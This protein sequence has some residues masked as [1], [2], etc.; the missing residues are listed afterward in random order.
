MARPISLDDEAVGPVSTEDLRSGAMALRS[1][2]TLPPDLAVQPNEQPSANFRT[3]PKL[4]ISLS[5]FKRCLGAQ[6]LVEGCMPP[7]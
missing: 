7:Q 3:P 1:M 6:T 4:P 5:Q 2:A